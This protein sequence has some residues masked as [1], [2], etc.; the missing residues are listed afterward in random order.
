MA[1]NYASASANPLAE[2]NPYEKEDARGKPSAEYVLGLLRSYQL[3]YKMFHDQCGRA[4]DY[5]FGRNAVPAPQG[6]EPVRPATARA[7][8]DTAT[9][10]VDVNNMEIDVPSSPRS[11]A[12][13]EKLKRFY[14]GSWLSIK[15]PV[16]RTA[17]RHS[18]AY[19][20]GFLKPMF[21]GD[22]W[23]DAP[24]VEEYLTDEGSVSYTHLT[25]PTKRIV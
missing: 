11:R 1:M 3:Y 9:D 20:I 16:L 25:L 5:Y 6:H 22:E 21:N 10:H 7:I 19:G 12:R 2:Y 17:V 4:E 15:G 23:P 13:A 24:P 8:V 14:Q 18:F